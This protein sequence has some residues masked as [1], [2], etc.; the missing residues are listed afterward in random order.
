MQKI[1]AAQSLEVVL[2]ESKTANADLI[3]QKLLLFGYEAKV[4]QVSSEPELRLALLRLPD[5]ILADLNPDEFNAL[6]VLEILWTDGLDIPVIMLC[7]EAQQELALECLTRGAADYLLAGELPRLGHTVRQI[8]EARQTKNE[9]AKAQLFMQSLYNSLPKA[10]MFVDTNGQ[11][12]GVNQQAEGLFGAPQAALLGTSVERFFPEWSAMSPTCMKN[13]RVLE[14]IR[15]SAPRRLDARRMDGTVFP[16][17]VSL[18][19]IGDPNHSA[20]LLILNDLTIQQQTEQKLT[21]VSERYQCLFENSQDIF[22]F[23]D[24]ETGQIVDAN[25]RAEQV[26]G[27]SREELLGMNI[28]QMRTEDRPEGMEH[29]LRSA[30]EEG[31]L[32]ETQHRKKDGSLIPL[33]VSSCETNLGSRRVKLEIARDISERKRVE[34]ILRK[35]EERFRWISENSLDVIWILDVAPLR[36]SYISPSVERLRG[37]TP[38]EIMQQTFADM[39]PPE[40]R[41]Q[42]GNILSK[43]IEAF[44]AGDET[45]RSLTDELNEVCKDGSRVATELVTTLVTDSQGKVTQ[46]VGVSRDIRQRKQSEA[47]LRESE[48]TYRTLVEASADAIMMTDESGRVVEWNRGAERMYG[49]D[50]NLAL[51]RPLWEIQ[52]QFLVEE[53]RTPEI[54]AYQKQAVLAVLQTGV[55]PWMG[56]PFKVS[57]QR[58]DGSLGVMNNAVYTIKTEKGYLLCGISRDLTGQERID[59]QLRETNDLLQTIIQAAPLGISVIDPQG[60]LRL[61]SPAAERL[62]GWRAEEVLG[63]ELPIIPA[64]AL[65]A[66]RQQIHEEFEGVCRGMESRRVHKDGSMLDIR[67]STAP[68]RDTQ[69]WITGSM[70]LYEDITLYKQTEAAVRT[71]QALLNAIVNSTSDMIWSVDPERF[72][73]MIFNQGLEDYFRDKRGIQIETG[74]GLEELFPTEE[75]IQLWNGFYER[76]LKDGPFTIEYQTIS[77]GMTLLLGLNPLKRDGEVFG[78]SVFAKDI[79]EQKLS[80][81]KIRQS[82]AGLRKAQ[83]VS[84]VGSWK[85]DISANQVE[86]SDE[87]FHIFG[88][89]KEDFTGSLS[90]VIAGAIHPDDRDKVDQSNSLVA[91]EKTP[92]PMEYR[93]IW[94]D[95]SIH[96]VWAEAGE[97]ILDPVGNPAFLTGIVQDITERKRAEDVLKGS[98]AFRQSILNS[99][100]S[101]ICVL[102]Q[103]GV[104]IAVNQSWER[105]G[106]ENGDLSKGKATG[107][108]IDY[109]ETVR[110]SSGED[111]QSLIEGI[112]EVIAGE[113]AAFTYEYPCHS[114]ELQRWFILS[115]TPLGVEK[116]GAVLAHINIS[117][118]KQAEEAL[119]SSEKKYR[120]LFSQMTSG[121][122]LHEIIYD[123]DGR[124]V[125]YITLDVNAAYLSILNTTFEMVVG[126]KASAVLPPEELKKWLEIFGPVASGGQ[127]RHYEMFSPLNGMYF[128]GTA[129]SPEKGKFAII[130]SDVSGY[131]QAIEAL[132]ESEERFRTLIEKAPAAILISRK[133]MPIY[134]NPLFL[135]MMGYL[136]KEEFLQTPLVENFP[137]SRREA[138]LERSRRRELGLFDSEEI[139]SILMRRDGSQFPAHIAVAQT[140]LSDGHA[141]I[142]FI[143][144]ITAQ[145]QAEEEIRRQAAHAHALAALAGRIGIGLDLNVKLRVLCE[146]T[147][148]AFGLSKIAVFL[149][150]EQKNILYPTCSQ[151]FSDKERNQLPAF[152]LMNLQTLSSTSGPV[153]VGAFQLILVPI[154]YQ[155]RLLGAIGIPPRT[156]RGAFS[157]EEHMLLMAFANQAGTAIVNVQLYEQARER[158]EELEDLAKVSSSLRKARTLLEIVPLFVA[159]TIDVLNAD[160]G[161]LILFP[162]DEFVQTSIQKLPQPDPIWQALLAEKSVEQALQMEQIYICHDILSLIKRPAEITGWSAAQIQSFAVVA[163]RSVD[164]PIGALCIGFT[165]PHR[166]EAEEKRLLI[167]LAEMAG[168]AIHRTSV[169]DTLEQRVQVHT[170]EL[171]VLY[172]I[173]RLTSGPIELEAILNQSLDR[174]LEIYRV[175][176]GLIQLLNEDH[177]TLALA[178]QRGL[179]KEALRMMQTVPLQGGIAARVIENNRAYLTLDLSKELEHTQAPAQNHSNL[180]LG[181]PIRAKGGVLGVVSIFSRSLHQFSVE[182]IALLET[183]ATQIGV[184]VENARLR[185]Q[186]QKAAIL[187]ERQRLA[188]DLHDSVTQSLYSLNLLAEGYRQRAAQAS[189]EELDVWFADLG[190]SAHQALKDMRLL[191]YELRPSSIEHD[192]LITAIHRRLD[193]VEGRSGVESRLKLLGDP[194]LLSKAEEVELY[195]IIQ[196]ALNNALKHALSTWVEIKLTVQP[197]QVQM[198]IV[199]NGIGFDPDQVQNEGM[200]LANMAERARRIGGKLFIYS[201]PGN[202]TRIEYIKKD[203]K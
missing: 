157:Q 50:K 173:T 185:E 73:L 46:M 59:A 201:Q 18:S 178:A 16:A 4:I 112:Q 32:F 37:F 113:K 123:A 2:L 159:E 52:Y 72:G 176:S 82:E 13:P 200:G 34:E 36:F 117:E 161:S 196:E 5:L 70:A 42:V 131:K 129:Y 191:L 25:R 20:V 26:Y 146:E 44:Y 15:W 97:L 65:D 60:D 3:A 193:A 164:H 90:D 91:Q 154:R 87:M 148:S 186:S 57:F 182:E 121:S 45:Q 142:S 12:A 53:Q 74:M 114:P 124:P 139:E 38:Q 35:S 69:G 189:L 166:I 67:L 187:E 181:A 136:S 102:D 172:D 66:F 43:R 64:D 51:G 145:K 128:E 108:G 39:A 89:D 147:A 76:A 174:V 99:M 155:E 22:L 192:G 150:G 133:G 23:I 119:S 31:A 111:V 101:N 93:I 27:Y 143:T 98:E 61:W 138:S 6:H 167:A 24:Q 203:M 110:R 115:V 151:G 1:P 152:S 95:Q 92:I 130:F 132:R 202:G 134:A 183:I 79:T 116:K 81:V 48:G 84:H 29:P 28:A 30:E 54:Y 56:R 7:T 21:T 10:L 165:A 80:E 135:K 9:L 122:A 137:P 55:N 85:W 184:A 125:D 179:P 149:S 156:E 140:H 11:V 104:I 190:S 160:T 175:E 168:N 141:N 197:Q 19:V 163:L 86:W 94:P 88:I 77:G 8:R 78:I 68:L 169:M 127:A 180:Y 198:E 33:E 144:D 58:M 105:F 71:S 62:F 14:S 171:E 41:S 153:E 188:R 194:T 177:Q 49:L 63:K 109:L 106:Q 83:Q 107:V 162:I 47:A 103:N 158:A 120:G 195:H 96:W 75:Y 199:D 17:E 40:I 100:G 126:K 170:R 118:R